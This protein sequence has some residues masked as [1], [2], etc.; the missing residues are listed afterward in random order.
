HRLIHQAADLLGVGA[1][2]TAAEDGEVLAEDED[3]ASVDETVAG[4]DAVAEDALLRHPEVRAAVRHERAG[5]DERA[6]VDEELDA[7]ARRELALL[8]L[9]RDGVRA[10]ALEGL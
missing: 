2:Q 4:D 7:L 1:R 8:V 3:R 6:L 5:L 10:A 9:L